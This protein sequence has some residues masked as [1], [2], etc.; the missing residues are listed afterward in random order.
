MSCAPAASSSSTGVLPS[1]RP[2]TLTA[3]P[4]GVELRP[5]PD[6]LGVRASAIS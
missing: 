4:A 6:Q 3:A 2:S 1:G 5:T